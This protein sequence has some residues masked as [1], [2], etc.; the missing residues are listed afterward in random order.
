LMANRAGIVSVDVEPN[1]G[2]IPGKL[3]ALARGLRPLGVKVDLI[4]GVAEKLERDRAAG[5]R[6]LDGINTNR[7]QGELRALGS[8]GERELTR[9]GSSAR[10]SSE[11]L[12]TVGAG[13]IY[14]GGRILGALKPATQAA[15]DLNEAVGTTTTLFGAQAAAV[16]QYASKAD[17][18]LGLSKRQALE[19]LNTFG[20]YAGTARKAGDEAVQFS[21]KLLAASADLG[22]A[23]GQ[24]T[25]QVIADIGSGLRGESDPLEKYGIFLQETEVRDA[26]LRAGLIK[27]KNE[28]LDPRAKILAANNIILEKAAQFEG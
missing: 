4:G 7:A 27:T 20:N 18:A 23:F 16:E 28:A 21:Q 6:A 10:L 2:A 11:A 5:Q 26:A 19:G 14:A 24:D 13:S 22:A 8:T 3:D 15:A 17:R 1:L 9:L 25:A 12:L